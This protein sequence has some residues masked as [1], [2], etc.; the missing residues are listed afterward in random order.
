MVEHPDYPVRDINLVLRACNPAEP[1][2]PGDKRWY[3][4]KDLR[5]GS[6]VEEMLR[7][8]SAT[9]AEGAFHHRILC[10]HRGNRQ[11]H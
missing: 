9:P 2:P 1:L 8:L 3:D 7:I 6:V 10:G 11:I 4:F 5:G